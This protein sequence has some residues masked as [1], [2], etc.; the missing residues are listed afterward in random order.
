MTRR[1]QLQVPKFGDWE[2]E[3]NVPYTFYF[4][5]ARKHRVS[6][7]MGR[8][9]GPHQKPEEFFNDESPARS[10][11]EKSIEQDSEVPRFG[12]WD[13]GGDVP[14]TLYFDKVRRRRGRGKAR[15]PE[16]KSAEHARGDPPAREKP[17]KGKSPPQDPQGRRS[18]FV[19][20]G[21]VTN[22]PV[23]QLRGSATPSLTG[24]RKMVA[25]QSPD[26]KHGADRSAQHPHSRARIGV[27][28]RGQVVPS[29]A[30]SEIGRWASSQAVSEGPAAASA[31]HS[32]YSDSRTKSEEEEKKAKSKSC[33]FPWGGK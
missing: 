30:S 32:F 4:D 16:N 7:E 26:S 3:G 29:G 10:R 20:H 23:N 18:S 31:D 11:K 28:E 25:R 27:Q 17:A 19:E 5:E 22:D 15:T 33:C 9:H 24:T 14:Y 8:T 12:G 13:G 6:G 1:A 2:G 21:K